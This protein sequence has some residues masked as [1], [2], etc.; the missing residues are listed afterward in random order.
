MQLG[1][2]SRDGLPISFSRRGITIRLPSIFSN[3]T[4]DQFH[5]VKRSENFFAELGG[6]LTSRTL[7]RPCAQSP[8]EY[9]SHNSLTRAAGKPSDFRG[10]EFLSMSSH[11]SLRRVQQKTRAKEA[12][13]ND[14]PSALGTLLAGAKLDLKSSL[15]K[16]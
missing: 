14:Y 8:I 9:R 10:C 3:K 15:R 13:A 4:S 12:R 5:C 11:C 7:Q 16:V 1:G 6:E 2:S